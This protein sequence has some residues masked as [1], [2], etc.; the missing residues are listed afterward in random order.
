EA[1]FSVQYCVA[2]A[3]TQGKVILDH[4]EGESFAEPQIQSLLTRVHSAPYTGPFFA[5]E[6]RF[7]AVVKVT[8]KGGRTVE[9]KVDT[10]LGRTV[11]NPITKDALNAKFHD[12]ATRVLDAASADAV[13]R[14]VWA[15]ES[16]ASVRELTT[17]L[18]A[19]ETRKNA[20]KRGTTSE[21][22]TA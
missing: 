8:L 2:R 19:G 11:K 13:C 22:V 15:L 21:A 17:L 1:K 12:C 9:T 16:L 3:L 6:D 10:P 5:D 14:Q 4:F 7:D 18:E 20:V